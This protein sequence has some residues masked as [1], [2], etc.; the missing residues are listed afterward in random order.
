M[1]FMSLMSLGFTSLGFRAWGL[2]L[3]SL[4][5]RLA[6]LRNSWGAFGFGPCF[7]IV[8]EFGRWHCFGIE[9]ERA[10]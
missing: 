2:P 8:V 3:T 5:Q 10:L 4:C 7:G 9:H 6:G 1:G